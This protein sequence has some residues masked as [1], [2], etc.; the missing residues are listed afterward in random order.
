MKSL[1]SIKASEALRA[2]HEADM[3]R[4]AMAAR[5]RTMLAA[6]LARGPATITE[7]AAWLDRAGDPGVSIAE[8]N[9][10]LFAMRPRVKRVRGVW[11]LAT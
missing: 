1:E 11:R 9:G 4:S 5:R 10:S 3:V 8:V 7:L 2:R 6:L